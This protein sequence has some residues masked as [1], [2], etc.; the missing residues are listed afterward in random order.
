VSR[1]KIVAQVNRRELWLSLLSASVVAGL[2]QQTYAQQH[3]KLPRIAYVSNSK[4]ND[5][6]VKLW[7]TALSELGYAPNRNIEIKYFYYTNV[8]ELPQVVSE[9]IASRPDIIMSLFTPTTLALKRATTLIP[10]V[11]SNIADPTASGIVE[12]LSAP[13]GNISGVSIMTSD[14]A[15]Q[16]LEI[17]TQL[18]PRAKRIAALYNPGNAAGKPQLSKALDAS[19]ALG[20]DLRP[21]EARGSDDWN[22]LLETLVQE[23]IQA[24]FFVTDQTFVHHREQIA[25]AALK[26]RLPSILDHPKQAAAGGLATYGPDYDYHYVRAAHY[27]ARVLNGDWPGNLPVEQPMKFE[28]Y[29][30]LNTARALG[31]TIPVKLRIQATKLIE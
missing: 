15:D 13:G 29:I 11:F 2:G 21:I 9:V 31:V 24:L 6:R 25:A 20:V 19:R 4:P 23:G 1:R 27:V 3:G 10:V 22:A 26:F 8:N 16:R 18:A 12:N 14:I 7:R 30:N 17:L 5:Y 28:L